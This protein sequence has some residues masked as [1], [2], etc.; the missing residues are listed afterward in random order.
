[1]DKVAESWIKIVVRCDDDDYRSCRGEKGDSCERS[2]KESK[3]VRRLPW[4][5]W[6]K[7]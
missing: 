1:M 3:G 6:G 4:L 7:Q 2:D 5:R